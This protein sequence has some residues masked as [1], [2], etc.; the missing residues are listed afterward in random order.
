MEGRTKKLCKSVSGAWIQVSHKNKEEGFVDLQSRDNYVELSIDQEAP[1]QACSTTGD[2]IQHLP[3][4]EWDNAGIHCRRGPMTRMEY[5]LAEQFIPL[6]V[7]IVSLK[8]ILDLFARSLMA[9]MLSWCH[10]VSLLWSCWG[11]SAVGSCLRL[12]LW[13]TIPLITNSLEKPLV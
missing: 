10:P 8:C 5:H 7:I 13:L 1:D 12:F 4:T 3:A 11:L 9:F 2:F 6:V